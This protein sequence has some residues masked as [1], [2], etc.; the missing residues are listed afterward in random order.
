MSS[1]GRR[2]WTYDCC[3]STRKGQPE[4]AGAQQPFQP[5]RQPIASVD[6]PLNGRL[7]LRR[8]GGRAPGGAAVR[9]LQLLIAP[10]AS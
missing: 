3:A 4:R 5:L 10:T 1:G 8:H 9:I 7:D 6:D 2:G